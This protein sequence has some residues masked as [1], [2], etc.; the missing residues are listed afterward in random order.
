MSG[1]ATSGSALKGSQAERVKGLREF[2]QNFNSTYQ[3]SSALP[4]HASSHSPD[5]AQVGFPL[6][7]FSLFN[8]FVRRTVFPKLCGLGEYRIVSYARINIPMRGNECTEFRLCSTR[9]LDMEPMC[10]FF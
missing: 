7:A 1:S 2:H 3:S 8:V 6:F 4:Q 9:V 10:S 5:E